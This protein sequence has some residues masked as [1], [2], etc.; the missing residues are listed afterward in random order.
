MRLQNPNINVAGSSLVS[1][2]S[3]GQSGTNV[4]PQKRL[5]SPNNS[6]FA[7]VTHRSSVDVAACGSEFARSADDAIRHGEDFH[8]NILPL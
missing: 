5:F 7:G 4:I 8:R 6:A 1:S 3:S 2:S